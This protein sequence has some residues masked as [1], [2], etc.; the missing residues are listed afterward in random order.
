M[1]PTYSFKELKRTRAPAQCPLCG[2]ETS[3]D[4][5]HMEVEVKANFLIPMGTYR[6]LWAVCPS[7]EKEFPINEGLDQV[8]A[9]SKQAKRLHNAAWLTLP[10]PFLSLALMILTLRH[11]PPTA[12]ETRMWTLIGLVPSSLIALMF[13]GLLVSL[14]L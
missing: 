2:L 5:R 13:I 7:C 8:L 9:A 4:L 1:R 12:N 6:E 14:S 10:I 11:T 3:L